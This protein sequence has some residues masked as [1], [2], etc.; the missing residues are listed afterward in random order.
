MARSGVKTIL[1]MGLTAALGGCASRPVAARAPAPAAALRDTHEGLQGVLWM[2]SSAEYW[3]LASA[4]YREAG[5][6]LLTALADRSSSAATEQ[7]PG[8]EGLPPAIVLDL[9]ETVLDNSAFQGQLVLD[10]TVYDPARWRAWVQTGRAG[11]I[12]GATGFL[13][14]AAS[15]GV[16][17]YFVTNRTAEEQADTL[18]TLE[19]AG[20]AASDDTVL[21]TG[22]NGWT[23]DKSARR[24][25]IARTHRIL[26]F[27]GD[28]MNDFVSTAG[29][30]ADARVMLAKTYADRW[31]R[32]W[33]L[34]PNPLYGSW[35][36]A[37][38]PGLTEDAEIL[39]R[40]RELVKGVGGR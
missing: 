20:I 14:L 18:R 9:D 7:P 19:Q 38:Y 2:Q 23:S 21:C 12:P 17:A 35:D 26:L 15:H 10:R 37:L 29:L 27:V 3:A 25:V 22:E 32:Q 28:D 4:T 6:A 33:F 24:A 31:G 16:T 5:Q 1:F 11:T 34:L 13:T 30:T 40:K 39:R 8:F 36:R